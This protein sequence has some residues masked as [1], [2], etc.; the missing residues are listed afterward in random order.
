MPPEHYCFYC[1][2]AIDENAPGT[3]THAGHVHWS[4]IT[5]GEV[6]L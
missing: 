3:M 1:G 5:A 2:E 6:E 4:H